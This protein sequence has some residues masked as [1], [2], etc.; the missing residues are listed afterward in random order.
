LPDDSEQVGVHADGEV[1]IDAYLSEAVAFA[2]DSLFGSLS[3]G[4]SVHPS[5][6]RAHHA[7]VHKAVEDLRYGCIAVNTNPIVAYTIPSIPWGAWN[8]AGTAESIG[9]GNVLPMCSMYDH[10]EK[11]VAWF[12][13]LYEPKALWDP[14]HTNTEHAMPRMFEHVQNR[15]PISLLLLLKSAFGSE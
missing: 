1:N 14:G 13:F 15:G 10:A 12:P 7:A 4:I 3:C 11:G 6:A 2:N 5:V 9:S 8:A